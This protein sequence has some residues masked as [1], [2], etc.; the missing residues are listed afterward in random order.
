M[1]QGKFCKHMN[2]SHEAYISVEPHD[3][4]GHGLSATYLCIATTK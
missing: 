2:T 3:Q 1:K 4:N